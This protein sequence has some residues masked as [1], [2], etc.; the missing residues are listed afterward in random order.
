MPEKLSRIRT[1]FIEMV[2]DAH[3]E[4]GFP[5]ISGW[6]LALMVFDGKPFAFGD[7]ARELNVSRG[8]VSTNIRLLENKKMVERIAFVGDRQ[9]YFQLTSSP[10]EGMIKSVAERMTRSSSQINR[11]CQDIKEKDVADRLHHMARFQENLSRALS[12]DLNE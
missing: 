7:I 10:F 1:Q 2:G 6:I 3:Q 5:R 8:S 11:L 4:Q 9:D 12:R